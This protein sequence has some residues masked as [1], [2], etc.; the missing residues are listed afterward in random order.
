MRV[1]E[2]LIA[3]IRKNRDFILA[4]HTSPDGDALGSSLALSSALESLGKITAVFNRDGV[5]E[6]YRFLPG[7]ERVASLLPRDKGLLVLLDCNEPERA[8]LGDASFP[9]SI[10]IDHHETVRDF[11]DIR[12]IEPH[13]ASTGMMV[14]YLLK[15][16]GVRITGDVATNLY[17][18]IAVDTGT[19]RYG[20]TTSEV[21]RVCA[22]LVDS[23]ADP[24]SISSALYEAWS[25]GRFR[26]LLSVLNTL[27]VVG[28]IA[29]T[30]VTKEM[31]SQTGTSPEDTEHFSSF[32]RMMK[33]IRVSAFFR[34]TDDGWKV[35]LRSRGDADVARIAEQFRGGGHKNAA[36][37]RTKGDLKTAHEI[38][39]GKLRD[40]TFATKAL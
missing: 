35:S 27:E 34:Q 4:T 33:D 6:I 38:L 39:I 30:Y 19:M 12:W 23:G 37:Y 20:N 28:D 31:F 5:P 10:V 3:L 22:E 21:L 13:A 9:Y 40:E 14:Y 25:Y 36:G 1:P 26:L 8:G 24:G 2:E 32:P 29:M 16:L 7:R 11:G 18:A 17:A 15:E